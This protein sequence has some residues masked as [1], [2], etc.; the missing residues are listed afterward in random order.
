MHPNEA[1]I[2]L[3]EA[4]KR[5]VKRLRDRDPDL[6]EML[7]RLHQQACAVN[8]TYVVNAVQ[9][10]WR[11]WDWPDDARN[12]EAMRFVIEALQDLGVLEE[13]AGSTEESQ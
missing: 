3:F 8:D 5:Y 11:E 10:V 9:R 12:P 2:R 13:C 7:P 1:S 6:Q 4:K